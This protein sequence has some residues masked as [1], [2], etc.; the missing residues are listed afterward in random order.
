MVRDP[1]E[2]VVK[3]SN[4]GLYIVIAVVAFLFLFGCFAAVAFALASYL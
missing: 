3:K 4:T 1:K 2:A